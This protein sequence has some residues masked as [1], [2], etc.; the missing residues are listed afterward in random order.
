[1]PS[2]GEWPLRATQPGFGVKG[3]VTEGTS[4][5]RALATGSLR[6]SQLKIARPPEQGSVGNEDRLMAKI[7]YVFR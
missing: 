6:P 1:M 2:H 3:R 5:L 4:L 7:G